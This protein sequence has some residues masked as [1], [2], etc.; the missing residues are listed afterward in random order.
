MIELAVLVLILI[1]MLVLFRKGSGLLQ[2]IFIVLFI[3]AAIYLYFND[4]F[5][6]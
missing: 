1:V 4:S 6:M 2:L 3:C 5:L